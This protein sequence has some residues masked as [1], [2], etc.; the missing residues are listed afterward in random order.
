M[1]IIGVFGGTGSGKTTIVNQIL[2]KFGSGEMLVIS[3]DAYYKDNSEISYEER[4]LLNYDHPNSIDFELLYTHL[5]EL[6]KGFSISQPVYDFKIHNR[7]KKTVKISPKK[8]IILEGILIMN[9]PKLRSILDLKVYIDANSDIRMERRVNRDI[10]ERGRTPKEVINR[11]ITMLIPMHKKFI[12]PM[13]LHADMVI[14]NHKNTP[15]NIESLLQKIKTM[16]G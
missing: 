13:K 12:S 16:L 2:S 14:E 11:Y 8:V 5:K 3:Q 9:Y 4:C 7:T 15:P 1:I 6:K 10:S